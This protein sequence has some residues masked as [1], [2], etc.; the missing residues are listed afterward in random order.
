[1]VLKPFRSV[2]IGGKSLQGQERVEGDDLT[3]P[4]Q[5][6][7]HRHPSALKIYLGDCVTSQRALKAHSPYQSF[8]STAVGSNLHALKLQLQI[9][10]GL[11]FGGLQFEQK[12]SHRGGCKPPQLC[13]VPSGMFKCCLVPIATGSLQHQ[14]SFQDHSS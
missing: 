11:Q 14:P 10:S 12:G 13:I 1:M 8:P 4:Q 9:R 7:H 2:I 5:S 3:V 6:W